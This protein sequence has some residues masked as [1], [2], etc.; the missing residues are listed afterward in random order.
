MV[1]NPN[2]LQGGSKRQHC[3]YLLHLMSEE[4][5]QVMRKTGNPD[6]PLCRGFWCGP[7]A[8][9]SGV[10][11]FLALLPDLWCCPLPLLKSAGP[12]IH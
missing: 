6:V 8:P 7:E 4:A 2:L 10:T 12:R 11:P 9:A 5:K 1:P 3:S